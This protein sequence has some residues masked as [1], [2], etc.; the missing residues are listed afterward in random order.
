MRRAPILFVVLALMAAL[1][2]ASTEHTSRLQ[3]YGKTSW[4]MTLDEVLR[5]EPRSKQLATPEL[6]N[7]G[8]A[9]AAIEHIDIGGTDL[10]VVFIF[11]ETAKLLKQ[12]NLATHE[13]MNEL[14]NGLSF[15]TLE[16]LLTEKYGSPNFKEDR[17]RASWLLDATIVELGHL[18]IRDVISQVILTYKPHSDSAEAT[19]DL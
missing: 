6:F 19:R 3:G 8:A 14:V 13:K 17:R 1:S 11:D 5:V 4:G 2:A 16:Q 10:R 9:L 12:V 7:T 15:S 18:F